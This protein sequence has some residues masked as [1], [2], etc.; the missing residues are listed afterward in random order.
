MVDYPHAGRYGPEIFLDERQR[1]MRSRE[2]TVY[3]KGTDTLATLYTD[4]TKAVTA[5]NP[6]VTDVRGNGTF[7]ANPAE[8]DIN[9]AGFEYTVTVYTDFDDLAVGSPGMPGSGSFG[10]LF[11]TSTADADPGSGG[12]RINH[13]TPA[14]AT[15]LYVDD[16]TSGGLDVSALIS[17]WDDGTG[18]IKG[19]L[20]ILNADQSEYYIYS[21]SGSIVDG[22]TYSK[23]P[24]TYIANSGT[25]AN[26]ELVYLRFS[27]TGNTGLTGATGNTGLTGATGATGSQGPAGATGL[28]FTLRLNNTDE[29]LATFAYIDDLAIGGANISDYIAAFDD[30]SGSVKGHM[31]LSN[32][33]KT[34][35]HIYKV[36]PPVTEAFGYSK[37]PIVH[38]GGTGDFTNTEPLFLVFSRAGDGPVRV[39]SAEYAALSPPDPNTWYVVTDT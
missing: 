33:D 22:G 24:L 9:Y 26:A 30:V 5:P 11:Q 20:E 31:E 38:I 19:Y 2:I 15:F 39:T 28:P 17:T 29:T 8:Y 13:A 36:G 37:V 10:F 3:V 32:G 12:V 1:L 35:I 7:Y 18:T 27:R 14:S 21:V 25:F 34:K 23:I 16:L 4:R 6:F